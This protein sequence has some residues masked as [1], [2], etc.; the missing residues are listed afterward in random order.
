M[1]K[2]LLCH[3][4]IVPL[5]VP[6]CTLTNKTENRKLYELIRQMGEFDQLIDESDFSWVHV[7]Y[8]RIGYNRRQTLKL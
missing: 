4:C 1:R 2:N 8:K 3:R 7:S 6:V 5:R